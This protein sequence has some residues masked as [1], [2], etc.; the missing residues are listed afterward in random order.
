[1]RLATRNEIAHTGIA[2]PGRRAPWGGGRFVPTGVWVIE[3][4][5]LRAFFSMSTFCH[6]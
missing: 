3:E 2:V 5:P 6:M 1:M 4:H